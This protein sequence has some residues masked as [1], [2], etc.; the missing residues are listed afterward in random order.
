MDRRPKE[1]DRWN[2]TAQER[3]KEEKDEKPL[4]KNLAER[5]KKQLEKRQRREGTEHQMAEKLAFM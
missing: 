3:E 5:K 1:T 4:Q 2:R